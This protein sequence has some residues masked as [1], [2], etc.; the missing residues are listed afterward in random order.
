MCYVPGNYINIMYTIKICALNSLT[1]PEMVSFF[2]AAHGGV[3]GYLV[4]L[5]THVLT[6]Y[7]IE[8]YNS[9]TIA[10]ITIVTITINIILLL[11][12]L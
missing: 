9:A 12:L 8:S 4:Y 10:I 3:K 11:V 5:H 2:S 6:I 1:G 7:N